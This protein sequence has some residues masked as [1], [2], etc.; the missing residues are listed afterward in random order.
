MKNRLRVTLTLLLLYSISSNGQSIITIERE[1]ITFTLMPS[2]EL[3]DLEGGNLFGSRNFRV[4]LLDINGSHNGT[5]VVDGKT[6]NYQSFD[7]ALQSYFD[8]VSVY[9]ID[10]TVYMN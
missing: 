1:G 8:Q 3:T 9:A 2:F 7:G 10:A 4:T 5:I 6:Y